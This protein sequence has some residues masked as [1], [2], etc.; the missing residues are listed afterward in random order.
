MAFFNSPIQPVPLSWDL[1][2]ALGTRDNSIDTT[3]MD[4]IL[5]MT[6]KSLATQVMQKI[7][8]DSSVL[9][10]PNGLADRKARGPSSTLSH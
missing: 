10:L 2:L 9:R 5:C 7:M 6:L 4:W 3:V 8:G 1:I